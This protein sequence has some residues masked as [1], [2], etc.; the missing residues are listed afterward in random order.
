[1]TRSYTLDTEQAKAAGLSNRI[2]ESGRYVGRFTRA[3]AIVSRSRTEG[4]EFTFE[5]DE[6]QTADY[7]TCWTYN[8]A[9]ESLYGLKVLNAVMTCLRVRQLAPR[10]MQ[11]NG[12]DGARQGDGF[13]DLMGKPVGLLLQ[14]EEYAKQDGSTGYKFNIALPFEASSG[15]TAGE[16]LGKVTAPAAL[17]KAHALLRDK[18]LQQRRQT[19][20][21]ASSGHPANRAQSGGGLADLDDDVPFADPYRGR[22][23]HVV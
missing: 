2:T 10:P 8:E 1:M 19:T 13:P 11:F 3:E 18:P 17:D 9:G 7:L 22:A 4:V 6:G 23:S 5:S 14:R 21:Y 12:R 16:I 20:E 15:L